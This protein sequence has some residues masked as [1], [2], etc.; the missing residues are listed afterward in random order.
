[1]T[2]VLQINFTKPL[3]KINILWHKVTV[4]HYLQKVIKIKNNLNKYLLLR[5]KNYILIIVI[6]CLL[7]QFIIIHF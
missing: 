1:M 3:K 2:K 4:G 6:I 5:K 7:L